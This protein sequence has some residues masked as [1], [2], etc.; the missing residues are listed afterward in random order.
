MYDAQF[1]DFNKKNVHFKRRL[2]VFTENF[3]ET[4]KKNGRKFE[5]SRQKLDFR[6]NFKV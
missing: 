3:G 5:I 1:F 4:H 6:I 2:L